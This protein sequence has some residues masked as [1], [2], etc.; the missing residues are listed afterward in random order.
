MELILGTAQLTRPYGIFATVRDGADDEVEGLGG[1][2][3]AADNLLRTA[4]DLG[5]T[6]LDT[7]PAYGDAETVI[8]A[9]GLPFSVHTKLAP[10]L[11]PED[12]LTGSL[13]RLQRDRVDVLHLHDPDAVHDPVMLAAA[14]RLVGERVGTL[15]ASVYTAAA[16]RAAAEAGLGAV[17]VP[18]NLL[19]RRIDDALLRELAAAG[20]RVLARSALL[21]GLLADPARGLG[22][23]PGLDGALR[24]F[25]RAAATLG[26]DPLELALGWVRARPSVGAVVL[27]AE[28]AGQLRR[29]HSA[30]LTPPLDA[31]ELSVL[32]AVEH[33]TEAGSGLPVDP[34][35]WGR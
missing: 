10:G 18:L 11:V 28:D 9:S 7:A 32:E 23:V 16:A 2:H 27:G 13:V 24:T 1:R 33:E 31:Q 17:Q 5:V 21:Q 12:S 3:G 15:G 19:D 8:G 26:R 29:L 4:V 34:R 14:M 25:A 22:R 35:D 20:V 6:T 30:F